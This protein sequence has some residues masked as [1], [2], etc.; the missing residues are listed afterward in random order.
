MKENFIIVSDVDQVIFDCVRRHYEWLTE[1]GQQNGWKDL[2]SF[3]DVLQKGGTHGSYGH[4]EGYWEKNTE[5]LADPDFN[6]DLEPIDRALEALELLQSSLALYLTTRPEDI[7]DLTQ[8]EL[9]KYGFPEKPVL[10]RPIDIPLADTTPWKMSVLIE[11]AKEVDAIIIMID[12]SLSLHQAL[13]ELNHPQIKSILFDGTITPKGNGEQHWPE[14]I[15]A[16]I[17][18]KIDPKDSPETD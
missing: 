3:E 8:A 2:P 10:A 12:D 5:M 14:I 11:M 13:N 6:T 16:L 4:Y 1:H 18:Q 15:D 17:G 7:Q 9:K